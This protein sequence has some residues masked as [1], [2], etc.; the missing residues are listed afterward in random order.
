MFPVLSP[1]LAPGTG[2]HFAAA[3]PGPELNHRFFL[4]GGLLHPRTIA[5]LRMVATNWRQCTRWYSLYFRTLLEND[6]ARCCKMLLFLCLNL[7]P[8]AIS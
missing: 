5:P 3:V 2:N 1:Y 4:G 6:V 8:A 7:S